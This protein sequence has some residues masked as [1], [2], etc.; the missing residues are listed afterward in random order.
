MTSQHLRGVPVFTSV[1]D[2]WSAVC[3]AD[4]FFW[5]RFL[6][7]CNFFFKKVSVSLEFPFARVSGRRS[8]RFDWLLI[9]R[10]VDKDGQVSGSL[11]SWAEVRSSFPVLLL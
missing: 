9:E 7:K 4:L 2:L 6:L 5:P 10:H 8:S 3:P 11:L 1:L